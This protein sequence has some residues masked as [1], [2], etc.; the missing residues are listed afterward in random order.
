NANY[1]QSNWLCFSKFSAYCLHLM[2][3]T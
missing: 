3:L 2:L 1:S